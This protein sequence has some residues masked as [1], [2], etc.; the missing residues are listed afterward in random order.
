MTGPEQAPAD[1]A[2]AQTLQVECDQAEGLCRF[3]E[4][5]A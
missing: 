1:Q 4:K 5:R 3:G 2:A